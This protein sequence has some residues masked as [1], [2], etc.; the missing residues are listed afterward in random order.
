MPLVIHQ[1]KRELLAQRAILIPWFLLL[2]IQLLCVATGFAGDFNRSNTPPLLKLL[3]DFMDL[4]LVL[5]PLV[6]SAAVALADPPAEEAAHWRT[7]P[8]RPPQLLAIKL[9]TL[10]LAVALPMLLVRI[11]TLALV[12]AGDW[13]G[14]AALDF[15][16]NMPAWILIG[17][18]IGAVAGTWKRFALGV[19]GLLVDTAVLPV[20][21]DVWEFVESPNLSAFLQIFERALENF[22][23]NNLF[24]FGAMIMVLLRYF[25]RLHPALITGCFILSLPR[26]GVWLP[27][28]FEQPR[29]RLPA[30]TDL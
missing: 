28:A 1:L 27:V 11:V 6:L 4:P 14:Y 15:I 13:S 22:V 17:F 10:V 2:L 8:V 24:L 18:S 9:L 30:E 19:I 29:S 5:G 7:L 20:F 21:L 16:G 12:G 23:D 25:T 26:L 3:F